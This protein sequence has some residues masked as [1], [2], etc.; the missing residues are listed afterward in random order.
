[1]AGQSGRTLGPHKSRQFSDLRISHRRPDSL[2]QDATL[3]H[4]TRRGAEVVGEGGDKMVRTSFLRGD[5]VSSLAKGQWGGVS[6][7]A[8]VV[9]GNRER[10]GGSSKDEVLPFYIRKGRRFIPET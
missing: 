3:F 1:M 7:L 2:D 8:L 6:W 4:E 10:L 5:V 9:F